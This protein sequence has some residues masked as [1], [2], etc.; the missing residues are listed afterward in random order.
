MNTGKMAGSRK[1][2][3]IVLQH[4]H[5]IMIH[6]DIGNFSEKWF[7]AAQQNTLGHCADINFQQN[8]V[9]PLLQ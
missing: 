5:T 3:D 8:T 4:L 1:C 7:K 9:Y 2:N 6:W